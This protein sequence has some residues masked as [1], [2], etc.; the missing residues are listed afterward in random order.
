VEEIK[1]L[2]QSEVPTGMKE[3]K[4]TKLLEYEG[5]RVFEVKKKQEEESIV[6]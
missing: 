6:V 5:E 3:F 4:R 2:V 1:K